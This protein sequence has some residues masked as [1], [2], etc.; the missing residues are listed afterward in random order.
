[1]GR[2]TQHSTFLAAA[3]RIAH[4]N[5]KKRVCLELTLVRTR[6]QKKGSRLGMRTNIIRAAGNC[7]VLHVEKK[8]KK[9]NRSAGGDCIVVSDARE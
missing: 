2:P 3:A 7:A 4:Y 1:M 6:H 9:N 8:F 5:N